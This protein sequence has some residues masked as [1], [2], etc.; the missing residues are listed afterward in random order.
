MKIFEFLKEKYHSRPLFFIMVVALVPRLIAAVFAKGYGMH[1]DMFGP[2]QAMQE[3]LDDFATIHND[4]PKLI[5]YPIVQY[6]IFAISEFLGIFEPQT[7]MYI[8]RFVHAFY[9]LLVVYFSYKITLIVSNREN[10][11]IVGMLTALLWMLP[12]MSVRNL[13]ELAVVPPVL[14]ATYFLLKYFYEDQS[15]SI[16]KNSI[17][18]RQVKYLILSGFF[19]GI[20]FATRFQTALVPLGIGL[21][22]IFRRQWKEFAILTFTTL[23]VSALF[24]GVLEY[25]IWHQPFQSLIDYVSYNS[26][27]YGNYP[28]SPWYMV[29]VLIIGVLLPPMGVLLFYAYLR[30]WKKYILL[31]LPTL[32]YI[33]FH[34]IYPN[35]QERFILT[36]LPMVLILCIIGF[37]EWTDNSTWWKKHKKILKNNWIWFWSI[38]T[39][40]L[41]LFIFTYSKKTRVESFTYLSKK[42]IT[43]IVIELNETD[44]YFAP[45][46][47]LGKNKD[48]NIYYMYS[49][50]DPE[51]YRNLLNNNFPNY[52]IFFDSNDLEERKN[53]FKNSYN[54]DIK[55]DKLIKPSLLDN[56]LYYMNPKHNKNYN[57]YIYNIIQ[58][59]N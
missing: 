36:I 53:K 46:F 7:K 2:V 57:A 24:I 47:Y 19:F 16:S 17:S 21:V 15:L 39:I 11:K 20:S 52:I 58:N 42:N 49:E 33:L 23:F 35:K 9:S 8:V 56:I 32:C 38:N 59:Q 13:V 6:V 18:K 31:F 34:S 1:D 30:T 51:N 54:C 40:L 48:K 25:L 44:T 4:T 26:T 10:A 50:Y 41:I 28:N 29:V 14:A 55:L 22:L 12:Y 43:S 27:S 45:V 37:K 5:L 3:L